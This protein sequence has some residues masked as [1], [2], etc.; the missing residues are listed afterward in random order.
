[1]SGRSV[2][3][4]RCPFRPL[5]PSISRLSDDSSKP[6]ASSSSS[7]MSNSPS[8]SPP[9]RSPPL[10]ANLDRFLESTTPVVPAQYFP[11]LAD[12]WESFKEW[13]AYGAGVP[14]VLNGGDCVVQYYVPYL[15]AIQLYLDESTTKWRSRIPGA[16]YDVEMYPVAGSDGS[17]ES[18]V[19]RAIRKRRDSSIVSSHKDQDG[20]VGNENGVCD[21]TILPVF[22]YLEHDPPYG[23]EPLAE[24]ASAASI[25][26]Y[27]LSAFLQSDIKYTKYCRF[28]SLQTNFLFLRRT[29]ALICSHLVGSLLLDS[30]N[31]HSEVNGISNFKDVNNATQMS[32][33]LSLPVFGLASYKFRG[34]IWTTDNL[35][36]RQFASSLLQAAENRLRLLKV[37]HPDFR[38]FLSHYRANLH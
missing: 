18:E 29:G 7:S 3:R 21:Q 5:P 22:E 12:L 36:E 30:C 19:D 34:S 16:E 2:G 23:R 26:L 9:P 37:D 25:D 1:M 31:G 4:P 17:S 8:P 13:S 28:L 35:D 27:E 14:L 20:L 6:Y 33:M 38:F 10:V 32:S 15:S 24:K 11:S